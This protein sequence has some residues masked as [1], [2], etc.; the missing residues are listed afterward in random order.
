[1]R[2][3]WLGEVKAQ[4][5][6]WERALE[7][8]DKVAQVARA[9]DV[10]YLA[11]AAYQA[12]AI[13][14]KE[15]AEGSGDAIEVI[16]EGVRQLGY[17]HPALQDYLAKIYMLDGRY[18]GA[19]EVWRQIPP[20]DEDRQTSVRIFSHHDALTCAGRL[21]DWRGVMEFALQGEKVAR[22]LCHLGD[23]IAVGFLAEHALAVWNSGGAQQGLDAFAE[24][25]GEMMSLPD[26]SDDLKSYT[27]L[28][29]INYAI[30]WL[31]GV[32]GADERGA[33]PRP[34]L[35]SDFKNQEIKREKEF[36]RGLAVPL[37]QVQIAQLRLKHSLR[38]LSIGPLISEYAKLSAHSKEAAGR[39]NA[40]ITESFDFSMI[41]PLVFAALVNWLGN[42]KPFTL[43]MD[44]W[45]EDAIS[46]GL[47]DTNLKDYLDFVGRSI[48]EE[49]SLLRNTL[50]EPDEAAE[51]RLTASLV[52]SHRNSLT[53]EDRFVANINLILTANA[54]TTWREETEGIVG[55]LITDGWKAV[56]EQQ[57]FLLSAPSLTVPSIM[58][59]IQ[60][61]AASGLKKAARIL[62]AVQSAVNVRFP[63]EVIDRMSEL[64]K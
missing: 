55:K 24:V 64:A 33:E 38:S 26:P 53:P 58:S 44:R 46:N 62:L 27:L 1:M 23:V 16:N 61:N 6:D 13:I 52:L 31:G 28:M 11:A 35:F 29:R 19:I 25:A 2:A 59:A 20:E 10:D 45:R 3:A 32:I 9:R 17:P 47:L 30:K 42:N 7:V 60:D 18:A 41:Y 21:S 37:L 14:L 4:S 56:I 63:P 40:P 36:P 12:K 8:L 54:Y 51:R 49:D 34:G 5:P 50:N 39:L 43:P 48:D 22:R 15:H 57:R